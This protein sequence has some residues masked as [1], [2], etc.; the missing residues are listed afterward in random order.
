MQEFQRI[1]ISKNIRPD[2]IFLLYK[3]KKQAQ[4]PRHV[5]ILEFRKEEWGR[6]VDRYIVLPILIC[7]SELFGNLQVH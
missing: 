6:L 2:S 5:I 4:E 7:T 3:G 1:T